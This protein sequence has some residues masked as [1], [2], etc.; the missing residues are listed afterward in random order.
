M[1]IEKDAV[2]I[3]AGVMG[4]KTTG[5]PIA[6]HIENRDWIN[7]RGK[8]IAPMTIP[9]PGHADLV[10]AIKYGHRDLRLTLERASAR[11]T[12]A[13]VAVGAV[14]RHLLS[15]F[16]IVIGSYVVAV[17]DLSADLPYPS[18]KESSVRQTYLDRFEAAEDNE[19]RCPDKKAVRPMQQVVADTMQ[20]KDTIGGIFEVVALGV[21]PGLGSYVHWDCRL[22]ARLLGAVGS[23]Q[24]VKGV[25]IGPAF[26]NT[27]LPGSQVHDEIFAEPADQDAKASTAAL[28][29]RTNRCG[30]MEG[31]VSTGQPIVVRGAMKPIATTLVPLQSV[32][33]ATGRPAT[34]LYERSDYCAVPRAAVVA[35]AMV[36]FVLA[37]TLTEKL[38]GDSL[39]EMHARF[40][41]LRPGKLDELQMDGVP[42]QFGYQDQE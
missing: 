40:K 21:P 30:G 11:E 17:G 22:S 12:A 16:G 5:S 32:D 42:W 29:R 2:R 25:E 7:W 35:E 33:L 18:G 15:Q 28:T 31:G 38:G 20:A 27:R 24:A 6:L 9:R 19:V 8:E 10:G 13:R 41:A 14:C 39:A 3:T 1:E 23:I 26:E 36:A 37:D 34:T 4:G